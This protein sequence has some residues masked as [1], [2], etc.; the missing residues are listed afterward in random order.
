VRYS[1]RYNQ[2]LTAV[3]DDVAEGKSLDFLRG[4]VFDSQGL[5]SVDMPNFA[6]IKVF[7]N[8]AA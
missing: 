4:S 8:V 1:T 7:G 2:A 5:V 6:R 3:C